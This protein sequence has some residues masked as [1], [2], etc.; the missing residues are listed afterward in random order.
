MRVIKKTI[1]QTVQHFKF[2]SE[3]ENENDLVS[4]IESGLSLIWVMSQNL[5]AREDFDFISGENF[6]LSESY[7]ELETSYHLIKCG[8]YKQSMISLRSGF[9]IGLLSIYWSII[10]K[11]SPEFKKWM[12]SKLPTPRKEPKFWSKLKQN[13]NIADFDKKYALI[14]EIKSLNSLSDFVHTKGYKFSNYGQFQRVV[15]GE[16]TFDNFNEWGEAFRKIVSIIRKLHLLVYPTFCLDYSTEFLISKFGTFGNIPQFGS[17]FGNTIDE[18][19]LFI[20]NE[21]RQCIEEISNNDDEVKY[22]KNWL[23]NLPDLTNDEINAAIIKSEK[24]KIQLAG[25]FS[26]WVKFAS[27]FDNRINEEIINILRE[28]A[29]QNNLMEL[30]EAMQR[31]HDEVQKWIDNKNHKL[32]V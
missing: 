6:S 27:F 5:P 24:S 15:R 10:G 3:F 13:Q 14:E 25:S 22:I 32:S 1:D 9:E 30:N 20:P 2:I 18:I 31:S 19:F 8:F 16:R 21:Q 17:G 26:M 7:E 23:G 12:S 4:D 11:N 29:E 28:W